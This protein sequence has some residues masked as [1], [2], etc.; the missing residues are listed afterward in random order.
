MKT[1]LYAAL[2]FFMIVALA[3]AQAP[4]KGA[5]QQERLIQ[6]KLELRKQNEQL[7]DECEKLK[8]ENAGLQGVVDEMLL[9]EA[10]LLDD[11]S[12]AGK[13]SDERTA[14]ITEELE[15]ARKK[16]AELEKDI[17]RLKDEVAA[18]RKSAG[19][20]SGPSPEP[21]SDL[22]RE[23]QDEATVYRK[24]LVKMRDAEKKSERRIQSLTQDNSKL[25][26]KIACLD[27]QAADG[28]RDRRDVKRLR[29]E[30]AKRDR[31][32]AKM[33]EKLAMAASG[34]GAGTRVITVNG[35][36]NPD[37]YFNTGVLYVKS[38]EYDKA[39]WEFLKALRL[40][41]SAADVHY[42]LGILYDD[43]LDRKKEAEKHYR[44]FL[45]LAPDNDDADNVRLWLLE[46]EMDI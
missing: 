46:L 10:K 24:L 17:A 1:V 22:F 40:D 13:S 29:S 41:P 37:L 19:R 11:L 30:L 25:K 6:E 45:E 7:K 36:E 42:N 14:V 5:D 18:A 23:L 9:R 38:G 4:E 33:R 21:G 44:K 8:E 32:L 34:E 16:N 12:R 39:E 31:D 28:K 26:Q 15:T 27:R 35:G 20:K 2:S 43:H 3:S